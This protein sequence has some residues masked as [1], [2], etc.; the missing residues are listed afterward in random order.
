MVMTIIKQNKIQKA[1]FF[2]LQQYLEIYIILTQLFSF[3]AQN[4]SWEEISFLY[5]VLFYYSHDH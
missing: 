2:W 3:V 1:N 5:F 4:I